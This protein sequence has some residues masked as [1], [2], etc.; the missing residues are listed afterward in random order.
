MLQ[1]LHSLFIRFRE[2]IV[3]L[4]PEKCAI[5]MDHVEYISHLIAAEGM[6]FTRI[7]LDSIVRFEEPKSMFQVKLFL[8]LANYFRDQA[9][10]LRPRYLYPSEGFDRSIV[11]R[12]YSTS[13][14]KKAIR[15][16]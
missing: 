10:R 8:G 7:K 5:G 4:S 14:S 15:S 3:I 6:H 12:S 11:R 1:R 16:I 2:Y 9:G 13:T